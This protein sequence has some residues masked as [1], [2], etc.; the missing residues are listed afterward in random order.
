[1]RIAAALVTANR[2]NKFMILHKYGMLFHTRPPKPHLQRECAACPPSSMPAPHPAVPTP[3]GL[4]AMVRPEDGEERADS[5]RAQFLLLLIELVRVRCQ[6]SQLRPWQ[7]AAGSVTRPSL[8]RIDSRRRSERE[9]LRPQK[10][11][12]Q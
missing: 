5:I 2:S 8:R 9:I 4:V 3:A 12:Q 6:L 10:Q 1:M 11:S 7:V